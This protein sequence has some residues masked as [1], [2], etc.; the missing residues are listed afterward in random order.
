MSL[1][2]LG[3]SVLRRP[4]LSSLA[5]TGSADI[6]SLLT[7]NSNLTA[8]SNSGSDYNSRPGPD[9]ASGPSDNL[10]EP[11]LNRFSLHNSALLRI[12][13]EQ[14]A[15]QPFAAAQAADRHA[16]APTALFR[17][18]HGHAFIGLGDA[19]PRG[20][21]GSTA[22]IQAFNS[23]VE[24]PLSAPPATDAAGGEVMQCISTKTWRR[25]KMKK[26]K[27][28]KRRRLVRHQAKK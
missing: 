8:T 2:F 25:L 3:R 7:Q 15:P 6:G 16:A 11:L 24:A 20:A 23:I 12:G 17:L 27:I 9:A 10:G 19:E 18:P 1:T 21:A 14:P 28:R 22:W 26:H 5:A 4:L 13:L